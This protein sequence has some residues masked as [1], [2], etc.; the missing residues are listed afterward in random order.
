MSETEFTAPV[1]R[2]SWVLGTACRKCERCLAEAHRF[3]P[4]VGVPPT[5]ATLADDPGVIW[6]PLP[7][8]EVVDMGRRARIA[9]AA[10]QGYIASFAG[11]P[12]TRLT[13]A[14]VAEQSVEFADAL[15]A[16]LDKRAG[17]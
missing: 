13:P 1:C 16:E 17:R 2:G 15:I 9:T 8:L 6:Q 12:Q 7:T 4:K 5:L 11:V 14:H 3:E 10:M